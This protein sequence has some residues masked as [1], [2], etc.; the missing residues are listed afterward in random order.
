[1]KRWIWPQ[2]CARRFF[3]TWDVEAA[4]KPSLC[5]TCGLKFWQGSN[6]K[7]RNRMAEKPSKPE[8]L[9]VV[10]RVWSVECKSVEC[11]VW[12]E[13][14]KVWSEECKV[15]SV[16]R[17][18]GVWSAKCE[19]KVWS[20]ECKVWSVER[21]VAHQSIENLKTYW[22]QQLE[23][24]PQKTSASEPVRQ[25][26]YHSSQLLQVQPWD[27]HNAYTVSSPCEPH[28]VLQRRPAHEAWFVKVWWEDVQCTEPPWTYLNIFKPILEQCMCM[29][30]VRKPF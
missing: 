22:K 9:S 8:P 2:I 10:C 27:F 17:K 15:W 26:S 4:L 18:C 11:K 29:W 1:M 19:C 13:E 16:E 3:Y 14:C 28:F 6:L 12:S 23:V 30:T 20:E 7:T 21:K 24:K 25:R 5:A